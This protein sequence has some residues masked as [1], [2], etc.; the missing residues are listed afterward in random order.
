MIKPNAKDEIWSNQQ[1]WT[2]IRWKLY[3]NCRVHSL[4][5]DGTLT[6]FNMLVEKRYP[7]IKE[8]LNWK[9]EAEAESTMALELLKFIKRGLLRIIEFYNLVLLIQLDTAG[10]VPL[11][12]SKDTK[13]YIKLRSSRSVYWDQQVAGTTSTTL[14]ARLPILNQ[15]AYLEETE[16]DRTYYCGRKADRR[17][18]WKAKGTSIDGT[19]NK[20]QLKFIHIKMQKIV[21]EA[22]WKRYGGD[23]R[24][25]RIVQRT[26]LKKQYENFA[27]LYQPNSTFNFLKMRSRTILI[28]DDLEG[29][30]F[31]QMGDGM[32][33]F[34]ARRFIKRTSRKLDV[35]GQMLDLIGLKWSA[36][37]VL[38]MVTLQENVEL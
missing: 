32:L 14:T 13:P 26:L 29:I 19:P 34:R 33:Q 2:L 25:P 35:N 37:I 10:D 11:D 24:N 7:L 8:M 15:G 27:G 16:Q 30:E 31:I 17:M 20:D 36:T 9:L 3:E 5:M 18:K 6:C 23:I 12:L 22:I 21:M 1:D 28:I 4:L 38:N